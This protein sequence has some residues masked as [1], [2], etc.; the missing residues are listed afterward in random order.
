MTIELFPTAYPVFSPVLLLKI[1]PTT[2]H[3]NP[4]TLI[5]SIKCGLL[6]KLIPQSYLNFLEESNKPN[7]VMMS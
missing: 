2:H 4:Q 3:I 1:S 7:Y 5:R 6:T